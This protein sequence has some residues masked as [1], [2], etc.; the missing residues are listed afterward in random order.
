MLQSDR[1]K[2]PRVLVYIYPMFNTVLL[3]QICLI[4]VVIA[5][6][7]YNQLTNSVFGL[8]LVIVPVSAHLP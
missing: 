3:L 7:L 8:I 2:I 5:L 4:L 1:M 6:T